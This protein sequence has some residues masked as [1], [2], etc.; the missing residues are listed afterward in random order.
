VVRME[1][2]DRD[3]GLCWEWQSVEGMKVESMR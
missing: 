2:C 3:G 1:V